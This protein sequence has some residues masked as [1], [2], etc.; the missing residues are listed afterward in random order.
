MPKDKHGRISQI[1]RL[2]GSLESAPIGDGDKVGEQFEVLPYQRR[3]LRGAC[4]P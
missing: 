1:S 3:F 2:I 4:G